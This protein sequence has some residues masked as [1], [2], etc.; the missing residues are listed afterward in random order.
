MSLRSS[1]SVT[2]TI[3]PVPQ[4][5]HLAVCSLLVDLGMQYNKTYKKSQQKILIGWE[6]PEETYVDADGVE[7]PKVVYNRYTNSLNEGCT[8]RRDLAAWRGRDFTPEE[9]ADF[10]LQSIV[11]KSCYLNI[12]HNEN[13]GKVYANISSII[14]LPKNAAKGKLSGNPL[15]F[16]LD[17]ASVE[18]VDKL[19]KWIGDVVKQSST[20]QDK[21]TSSYQVETPAFQELE[22]DGELPF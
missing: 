19:P 17:P 9:L 11:G 5:T 18:D 8:L 15:I 4:G 16:D 1:A 20:Y 12:I 3:E 22:D 14:A 7:K 2:S 13:N 6:I 10:D 21:L